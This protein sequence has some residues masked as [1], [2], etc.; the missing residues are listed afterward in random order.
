[1]ERKTLV[2]ILTT[3]AFVAIALIFVFNR[4][5]KSLPNNNDQ[6]VSAGLAPLKK[7]DV[8]ISREE[9]RVSIDVFYPQYENVPAIINS[10]IKN[11]AEAEIENI[12]SLKLAEIPTSSDAT[13][14]LKINYETEQA[15]TDY[16]SLVFTIN[17]Y[18]GGAHPNEYFRTFNYNIRD[19]SKVELKDIF[20][21]STDAILDL[22]P[23]IAQS[24][25]K[26]LTET[27]KVNGDIS[28]DPDELLFEPIADLGDEV[29][30][31]FTFSSSDVIFYFSPYD[32]APYVA[33]PIVARVER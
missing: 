26:V 28:S 31:N 5:Q 7:N 25:R 10:E 17:I 33:G 19:G 9:E 21:E 18:T 8:K 22:K 16:L 30:Q 6:Q 29:F 27:L 15:N 12:D 13:Y 11:F 2:Y 1:M 4:P 23:Q 32:I 14:F 24:V 20:P 3:L